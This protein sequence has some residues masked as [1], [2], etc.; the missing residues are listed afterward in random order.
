MSGRIVH[1]EENV[2]KIEWIVDHL[3]RVNLYELREYVW[4]TVSVREQVAS[5]I[6]LFLLNL[7]T[8]RVDWFLVFD[9]AFFS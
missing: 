4:F 3:V 7:I 9:L 6:T 2:R 5:C 1:S 8:V